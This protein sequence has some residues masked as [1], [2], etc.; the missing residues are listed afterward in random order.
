M[1]LYGRLPE[2]TGKSPM[3]KWCN[4]SYRFI[5]IREVTEIDCH[6][7]RKTITSQYICDSVNR[8]NSDRIT[9]KHGKISEMNGTCESM[10]TKK[11]S[12]TKV[13]LIITNQHSTALQQLFPKQRSALEKS[14]TNPM[15]FQTRARSSEFLRADARTKRQAS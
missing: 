8:K 4:V 12:R 15:E 11:F 10:L 13:C 1:M 7:S 5:H 2:K 6:H 3:T 14:S 9:K